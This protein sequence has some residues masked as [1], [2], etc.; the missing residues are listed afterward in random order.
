[1]WERNRKSRLKAARAWLKRLSSSPSSFEALLIPHPTSNS[2]EVSPMTNI[3][4]NQSPED[5]FLHWRQDM[6]K[7]QEEQARQMKELQGQVERLRR[8]NDQQRAQIQKVTI[9]EKTH[10]IT[11]TMRSRSPVIKRRGPLFLTTSI[12][13]RTMNYP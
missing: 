1:M 2:L 8:K 6:E 3:P 9:L 13:Q 7:K 11:T 5:Q 12:P 10:E 4:M